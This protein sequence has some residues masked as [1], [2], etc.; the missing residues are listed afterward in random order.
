M[1]KVSPF[2][3]YLP[4]MKRVLRRSLKLPPGGIDFTS[5]DYLGLAR[6]P[7]LYS[8]ILD[9]MAALP[10]KRN[11]STG[12]RLLSGNSALIGSAETKLAG[13]FQSGSALLFDS[14]YSANLAVL[15]TLPQRSD[16]IIMDELSHAS[17]KDGARLCQA[18]KWNFRHND[19]DDLRKKLELVA[20]HQ[21]VRRG[22][23]WI[24]VESLYS[25]DGDRCPLNEIITISK[26]YSAHIILDE[27]HT[28]GLGNQKKIDVAVRVC[29]FGKAMGVH[30]AC[31]CSSDE[32]KDQLINFS[33]P[34][35]YTTAP[36]DHSVV[37]VTSAFDFLDANKHL[38]EDLNEKIRYFRSIADRV[39]GWNK[40]E[41]QIQIVI[42]PGY[43]Q[44]T[45]AASH[46]QSAGYDV[47]PILSPTVREGQ[48]R[49]RICL[50]TF[51]T[52]KE[53]QG[54]VKEM[55]SLGL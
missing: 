25:M 30:G 32:I 29:T 44:V 19:P 7:E 27:A 39:H 24:V 41:S 54:L 35:I 18:T 45:K 46:L 48:E 28:T 23:K 1:N 34:F 52:E 50:H 2:P 38:Q 47:R 20:K 43:E 15:S 11:G 33:R 40:S 10:Q 4:N 37:S 49:L 14:G 36:S 3:I 16:T 26:D 22:E 6:S 55:I 31:V 5:N 13:L 21:D 9:A 51:N 53:M 8:K 42:V 17:L 12:S